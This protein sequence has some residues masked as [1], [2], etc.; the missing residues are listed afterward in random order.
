[1][2]FHLVVANFRFLDSLVFAT[3][4]WKARFLCTFAEVNNFRPRERHISLHKVTY[5]SINFVVL[6]AF[7]CI[8]T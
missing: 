3:F 5:I 1:M 7:Q 4:P 2:T 8:V 6:L